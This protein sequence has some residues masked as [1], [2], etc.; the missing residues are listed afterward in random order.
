MS[1]EAITLSVLLPVH[2]GVAADHF[3]RALESVLDQTRPP[4]EVVVV[5]DG[6][7]TPEHRLVIERLV[8]THPAA[9]VV[10]LEENSGAG[11]ANQAGL[12]AA[13]GT[14]IVKMDADDVCLPTRIETEMAALEV[15]GADVCG[16]A[17]LEFE[18]S[19]EH[20]VAVRRNPTTPEAIARRM[21]VNNPINHS[22]AIYR[23]ELALEVGGY[24]DL[25]FM[26]DYDLFARLLAH[27]A[28]F[29]NL[30]EPLVL[31]RADPG[32]FR[33]RSARTML[34]YERVLQ[35]N[36]VRYGLIG[37]GRAT[38]NLVLRGGVRLL[39]PRLLRA[40]Y[41]LLFRRRSK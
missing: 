2:A 24:P 32:M 28:R 36:L 9:V 5:E 15:S 3:A 39:P 10:R 38:V 30:P 31:F 19:E 8:E 41:S 14:W 25:R 40:T 29:I 17:M 37:R 27:G 1:E 33:R 13:S 7:L 26:Q 20:V 12:R 4:D 21:K 6:P 23:R 35:R 11:V 18:V 16:A 22:T 34:G